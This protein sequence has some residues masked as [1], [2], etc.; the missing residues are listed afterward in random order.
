MRILRPSLSTAAMVANG[1]DHRAGSESCL[2]RPPGLHGCNS[3]VL[4]REQSRVP[5][6]APL[7][8]TVAPLAQEGGL[9]GLFDYYVLEH[10]VLGALA[11]VLAGLVTAET[12]RR[13]GR[14]RPAW[15]TFVL[16]FA[17][18][19]A[20]VVGGESVSTP[21]EEMT[22]AT[23]EFVTGIVQGKPETVSHLVSEK[24]LF[25][26]DGR[27]NL[28]L[29]RSWLISVT[30]G[31]DGAFKSHNMEIIDALTTNNGTTGQTRFL[32]RAEFSAENWGVIPSTWLLS[33]RQESGKWRITA[34]ECLT[35][36]GKPA[37]EEWVNWGN[38]HRR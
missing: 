2:Y 33:W 23:H 6:G 34:I 7:I 15:L 29:D 12:L 9:G 18:A 8:Q 35:L 11:V 38:R 4:T 27:V 30:S 31:L 25:R 5:I 3:P 19:A 24:V 1:R 13:F 22:R 28:R 20:V 32:S 36:F 14:S 37:S 17:I 21:R 16:T 26:T 10:P